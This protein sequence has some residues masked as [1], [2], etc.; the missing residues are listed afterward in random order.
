MFPFEDS[1]GAG[2]TADGRETFAMQGIGGYTM[3]VDVR[4]KLGVG[5]VDERIVLDQSR[6]GV[7]LDAWK[8]GTVVALGGTKS[9]DPNSR[10][11]QGALERF[12]FSN[13]A[14]FFA[15]LKG[16]KY[17]RHPLFIHKLLQG[18]G[19]GKKRS[20]GRAG[21]FGAGAIDEV[22]RLRKETPSVQGHQLH[23]KAVPGD[24]V[25]ECLV[26][27]SQGRGEHD[28]FWVLLAQLA[29]PRDGVRADKEGQG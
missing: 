22:V 23:R 7:P 17:G 4:F 20:E 15:R 16:L 5:P 14:A 1:A 19:V 28:L 10:A 12:D 27:Q 2:G 13:V 9:S 8:G 24:E 29:Q 3:G 21:I 26:F 25:G 6:H 11:I 18:G